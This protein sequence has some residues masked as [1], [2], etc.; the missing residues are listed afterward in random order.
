MS[1]KQK[2][3]NICK[4]MPIKSMLSPK[5]SH[6]PQYP[7]I[8]NWD[9]I[10]CPVKLFSSLL[11]SQ[12]C[13]RWCGSTI[14]DTFCS[15]ASCVWECCWNGCWS[16]WPIVTWQTRSIRVS[17]VTWSFNWFE[18]RVPPWRPCDWFGR[19]HKARSLCSAWCNC[20]HLCLQRARVRR[21]NFEEILNK[22]N[23]YAYKAFEI[24][25][26][27]NQIT[28]KFRKYYLAMNHTLVYGTK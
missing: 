22:S 25:K 13:F 10:P 26:I 27:K 14:S 9:K 18:T 7:I 5:P 17:T 16:N 20:L 12:V 15:W 1:W 24:W 11:I 6:V 28:M 23:G 4:Y 19:T 3:V 8:T 21:Q 2:R